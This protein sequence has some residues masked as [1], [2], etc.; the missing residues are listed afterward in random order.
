MTG[1]NQNLLSDLFNLDDINLRD[2][3]H[4]SKIFRS[5]SYEN[6]PKLKFLF[7]T[8]F[9]INPDIGRNDN[10]G[11]LV[12]EITLPKF[13]LKTHQLNQ[14]NRKRITQSK[15]EYDAVEITFH[16]DG[17]NQINKLWE[18]YYTYYYNDANMPGAVLSNVRGNNSGPK[19]YNYRNIYDDD[20][21]NSV[22][23]GFSGGQ[24]NGQGTKI[25]F[26]KNIT[27]FGFNQ[28]DFTAYTLINPI[29]KSF[30]HDTYNYSSGAETMQNRMTIDYE[31]VVYNY[32][33]MDGRDPST[34]VIGFGETP[35]YDTNPSPIAGMGVGTVLGQGGL[36][37]AVGGSIRSLLNGNFSG[38]I[39]NA[40][41]AYNSFNMINS[42]STN[43]D[44]GRGALQALYK[45]SMRNTPTTRN[46][47][48]DV[49]TASGSP[50]PAGLASSPTIG[51]NSVPTVIT[52][53]A[54]SIQNNVE[55]GT[56]LSTGA[57]VTP[58]N[59][60]ENEI[61]TAAGIQYSGTNLAVDQPFRG[62][63]L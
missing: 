31:T 9:Q 32:G 17:G 34:I 54:V 57:I 28:H 59:T 14:Y 53:D 25:P 48:F 51:I 23:W 11:L 47:L 43:Q 1:F 63:V 37:D 5:N 30:G 20:I 50:G 35:T 8:Y 13:S 27:I 36:V 15:I 41:V 19:D 29:I 46:A 52:S 12:K 26:F 24:N 42:S 56:T 62:Q 3:I 61:V 40:S 10:F 38:A 58:I 33:S 45:T 16:D 4:A 6:A 44:I 39:A 21:T 18:A 49:P 22:D 60:S 55:Y 7:H 2:Y